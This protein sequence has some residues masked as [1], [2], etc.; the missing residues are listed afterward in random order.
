MIY[1]DSVGRRFYVDTA[2][3]SSLCRDVF[4]T[5]NITVNKIYNTFP[6][7]APFNGKDLNLTRIQEELE[8]ALPNPDIFNDE[9]SA[10]LVNYGLHFVMD[11][12]FSTFIDTMEVVAKTLERYENIYKG[13]II[14]KTTNAMNKWKYGFPD[15]IKKHD[16]MQRF[17]TEQVGYDSY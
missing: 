6:G 11:I 12:P 1:G 15:Q 8:L 17:L 3:T 10:F 16:K 14:W 5:C 7:P 2:N 9:N 4:R 13:T